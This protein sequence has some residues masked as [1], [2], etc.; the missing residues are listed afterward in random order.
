MS[1][2]VVC[3]DDAGFARSTDE[4]ILRCAREGIVCAASVVAGGPTAERFLAEA[5]DAG[6]ELGLH[7]N[8]TEGRALA[9]PATTLTD[10]EA[11]FVGGEGQAIESRRGSDGLR[12]RAEQEQASHRGAGHD[13]AGEYARGRARLQRAGINA[14][15]DALADGK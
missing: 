14:R 3:A 9:G 10:G 11:F 2:L 13:R 15:R 7:F 12:G 1:R 6:L 5:A 4:A 8:L